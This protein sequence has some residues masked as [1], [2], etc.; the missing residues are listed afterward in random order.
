MAARLRDDKM[1]RAL[2]AEGPLGCKKHATCLLGSFLCES[3]AFIGSFRHAGLQAAVLPYLKCTC[4]TVAFV[5]SARWVFPLMLGGV[6]GGGGGGWVQ[7]LGF[8]VSVWGLGLTNR[9]GFVGTTMS[10]VVLLIDG[11]GTTT[12]LSQVL[13]KILM[14]AVIFHFCIQ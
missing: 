4:L 14:I 7:G 5:D 11:L 10:V 1:I 6:R 3:A 13:M 8:R 9:P 12:I 2:L